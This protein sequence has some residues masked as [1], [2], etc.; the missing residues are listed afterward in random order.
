MAWTASTALAVVPSSP[1]AFYWAPFMSI[2][3]VG[4]VPGGLHDVDL[5]KNG[6]RT[7]ASCVSSSLQ[8]PLDEP[9]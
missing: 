3:T 8:S 4:M 2:W 5:A 1:G 6:C 9:S 7:G